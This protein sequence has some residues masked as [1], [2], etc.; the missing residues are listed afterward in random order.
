MA[1]P[2]N[3]WHAH[4]M[5]TY[6]SSNVPFAEAMKL[7]S[8][9]YRAA[10]GF[11]GEKEIIRADRSGDKKIKGFYKPDVVVE[12]GVMEKL[13][14]KLKRRGDAKKLIKGKGLPHNKKG[15]VK[16]HYS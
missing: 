13:K 6:R 2:S 14:D 11:K 7:A 12:E 4:L 1:A 10:N 9:T 15:R 3:P 8:A 16:G 5:Q